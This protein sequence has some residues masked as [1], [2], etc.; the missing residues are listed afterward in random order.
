MWGRTLCPMLWQRE[1]YCITSDQCCLEHCV[2]H[3]LEEVLPTWND[4]G[5]VPLYYPFTIHRRPCYGCME[6]LAPKL[7]ECYN[8]FEVIEP[9][10]THLQLKVDG[11]TIMA[12]ANR[13]PE[14]CKKCQ[15]NPTFE[16]LVKKFLSI[17][18]REDWQDEIWQ[19]EHCLTCLTRCLKQLAE[20]YTKVHSN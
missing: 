7:I 10:P 13:Q 17:K 9:L 1:L 8:C 3:R 5:Q 4:D 20:C 15:N 6:I 12:I 16:V 11:K 14:P 2:N 19:S 18:K